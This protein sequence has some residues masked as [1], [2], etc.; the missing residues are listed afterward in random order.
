MNL[1]H[2][3][4]RENKT[5]F[6]IALL[7]SCQSSNDTVLMTALFQTRITDFRFRCMVRQNP[8][9][10]RGSDSLS[11]QSYGTMHKNKILR[12]IGSQVDFL[13]FIRAVCLFT[14]CETTAH[15]DAVSTKAQ[16]F[17]N[18]FTVQYTACT[19]DGQIDSRSDFRNDF[20]T[21]TTRAQMATRF[22]TS[23]APVR[24]DPVEC[25]SARSSR[26]ISASLCAA[27]AV[28]QEDGVART[29]R[30]KGEV[31]RWQERA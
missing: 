14:G 25:G 8:F 6:D 17:N 7:C 31:R 3:P 11:G 4:T 19:D 9:G 30:P 18:V 28:R 24:L 21:G 26:G 23:A 10:K 15:L 22:G 13:Q 1:L 12:V 2:A 20:P 27:R 5:R 16:H 29:A